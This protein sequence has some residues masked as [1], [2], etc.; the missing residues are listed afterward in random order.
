MSF[1]LPDAGWPI[2]PADAVLGGYVALQALRGGARGAVAMLVAGL[3]FAV[4]L[5]AA[6]A[7]A[8]V[9]LP[10]PLGAPQATPMVGVVTFI[11]A[12]ALAERLIGL[13]FTPA[14]LSWALVPGGRL[15]ERLVGMGLGTLYGISTAALLLALVAEHAAVL[16]ITPWFDGAT[17]SAML[18]DV[19]KAGLLWLTAA[20]AT[21]MARLQ[22]RWSF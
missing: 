7:A 13:L 16:P 6:L 2:A 19:G 5:T 15:A 10:M 4:A 9:S 18:T 12:H 3:A 1:G 11:A 21:V 17:Y 22:E 8:T 14:A 20:S